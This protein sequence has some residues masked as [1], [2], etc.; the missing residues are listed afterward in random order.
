MA[1]SVTLQITPAD[2]VGWVHRLEEESGET[3]PRDQK[4]LAAGVLVLARLFGHPWVDSRILKKSRFMHP[5][6]ATRLDA[7]KRQDRLASL[8]EHL[9]NLQHIEGFEW[10]L[11][12][13]YTDSIET[14]LAK[15]YGAGMLRRAMVSFCFIVPSGKIKA[16]YDAE[17]TI[18]STRF[19]IE[20]KA[21]IEGQ[22]PSAKA[23]ADSLKRARDQVPRD[24][25]NLVFLRVPGAWGQSQSGQEAIKEGAEREFANSGS[26]GALVAHWERWYDAASP[27]QPEG[28]ARGQR[29]LIAPSSRARADFTSLT[30]TLVAGSVR[31]SREWLSLQQLFS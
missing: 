23:V 25:P 27:E 30:R 16:D 31:P 9:V 3:Y 11:R 5:P 21:K 10:C 22:A 8:A 29:F 7:F 15:L 17:A 26:I 18:G 13:I 20:M 1:R 2:I 19:P 4:H 28:A 6:V 12:E 14:G 24:T